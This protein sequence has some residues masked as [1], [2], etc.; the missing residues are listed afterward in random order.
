VHST[1]DEKDTGAQKFNASLIFSHQP[2]YDLFFAERVPVLHAFQC[3]LA[4]Y[5]RERAQTSRNIRARLSLML[6]RSAHPFRAVE[7]GVYTG[8]SL[9]ACAL[10]A[11]DTCMPYRIIGLDTF[12]GLPPLSEKDL[13]LAPDGARYINTQMFGDT[14]LESVQA[15]FLHA[16]LSNYVEL[17]KGLFRETLPTLPDHRY[18]FVNI[19]CDLYEPHIECLEYFYPR[20]VSGGIVFFDDYHSVEYPMAS[21]AVDDFMHDKPEQLLHLRFGADGVN[22]TKSFFLK[23]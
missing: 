10:I 15:K 9:L 8:S 4:N 18:H 16:G 2:P 11:R 6:N 20:M 1:E 21:R 3:A 23:Y 5:A 19:D 17:R 12:S 13:S 14:S 22:R 7:C